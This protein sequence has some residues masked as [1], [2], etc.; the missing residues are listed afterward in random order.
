[1]CVFSLLAVLLIS[2]CA[3]AASVDLCCDGQDLFGKR[4]FLISVVLTGQYVL[5]SISGCM[6]R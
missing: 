1:M 3:D 4:T 5:V 6:L 2:A